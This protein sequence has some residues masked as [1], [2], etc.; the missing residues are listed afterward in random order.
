[1]EAIGYFGYS[2]PMEHACTDT[3][4]ETDE[5]ESMMAAW[6]QTL[7]FCGDRWIG[8]DKNGCLRAVKTQKE[9]VFAGQVGDAN[10]DGTIDPRDLLAV[11][12]PALPE[13]WREWMRSRLIE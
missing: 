13:V 9:G 4:Y 11:Y 5:G 7:V 10:L 1:M 3:R 2:C 12:D 8:M 6:E